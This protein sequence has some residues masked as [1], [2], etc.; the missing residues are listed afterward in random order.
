M[1]K[2]S[3][4]ILLFRRVEVGIEVFLVHPGGPFWAKKDLGAWSLPKGE[5]E[6]SEDPLT[7]AKREFTEETGFVVDGSFLKLGDLK[8]PSGKVITAWALEH[9]LDPAAIKSNSFRMEWPPKS[10]K[11]QDFPEVDAGAW[12]A[13]S[14]AL[15]KLLKGQADFIRRLAE[16]VGVDVPKPQD[17]GSPDRTEQ[18]A[19]F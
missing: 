6:E 11:M 15:E 5:Y 13:L 8:Q 14:A 10:G 3:A 1:K 4:G 9:N 18:R 19:L 7:A 12:Y 2:R 17:R 16:K